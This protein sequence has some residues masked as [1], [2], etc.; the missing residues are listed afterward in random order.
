MD[1]DVLSIIFVSVLAVTFIIFFINVVERYI[2]VSQEVQYHRDA[3]DFAVNL[4]ENIL[5]EGYVDQKSLNNYTIVSRYG[6]QIIDYDRQTN[7][8]FGIVKPK[9]VSVPT[10]IYD[11]GKTYKALLVVRYD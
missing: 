5:G 11:N 7:W 9:A 10:L 1:E 2:L 6:L 4:K 3:L 8:S